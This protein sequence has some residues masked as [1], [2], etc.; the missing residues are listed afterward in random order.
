MSMESTTTDSGRRGMPKGGLAG[1]CLLAFT[2]A[3]R[4]LLSLFYCPP[5]FAAICCCSSVLLSGFAVNLNLVCIHQFPLLTAPRRLI[6]PSRYAGCDSM[7]RVLLSSFAGRYAL[8]MD[9][10][11]VFG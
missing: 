11:P 2:D 1:A 7:I 9:V 4:V 8:I 5:S 10:F 3:L 6:L